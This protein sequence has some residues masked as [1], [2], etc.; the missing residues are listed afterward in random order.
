M[1]KDYLN[2][3]ERAL[4]MGISD[5]INNDTSSGDVYVFGEFPETE[6]M[7]FPLVVVQMIG[8]GFDE[9]FFG[10]DVT[11]GSSGASGTGEVYGV[12]YLV[13][14]ICEKDT[15][16]TISGDV[17]KQRKLLNWMMLN[18]A[19]YVAD[20]DWTIYEEEEL[21]ILERRLDG[22][23]DI[24]YLENFQWYGATAQFTLHFKNY[25]T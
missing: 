14:L 4:M 8:S 19:N 15:E 24:G 3:I 6:D 2:V 22:W 23:R 7:K 17:Y 11:F 9:Q 10:Q 12:Q 25:R 18:I 13:H 16:L 5:K 20:I 1:A 21:E